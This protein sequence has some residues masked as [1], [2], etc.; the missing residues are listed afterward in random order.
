[1][2]DTFPFI[3]ITLALGKTSAK[4]DIGN[5]PPQ[6]CNTYTITILYRVYAFTMVYV[7][8]ALYKKRGPVNLNRKRNPK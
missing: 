5:L 3:A 1:L 7:H 8:R 6:S 2:Q 4:T